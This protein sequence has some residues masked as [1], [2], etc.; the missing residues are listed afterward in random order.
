MPPL[1]GQG[2]EPCARGLRAWGAGTGTWLPW[3]Q[4]EHGCC[5]ERAEGNGSGWMSDLPLHHKVG[6]SNAALG[7][8]VPR[9]CCG[10]KAV[11]EPRWKLGSTTT[12]PGATL[13]LSGLN[14]LIAFQVSTGGKLAPL[15]Q[16]MR[17][18]CPMEEL[19]WGADVPRSL[20]CAPSP[21]AGRRHC[22]VT[23]VGSL[24]P[25]RAPRFE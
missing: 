1:C 22:W 24:R 7:K 3:P 17:A 4:G 18:G 23:S 25:A 20:G 8:S 15:G 9:A 11:W 2:L 12:S 21:A 13:C 5:S 16:R 14:S 19:S 6:M 10:T